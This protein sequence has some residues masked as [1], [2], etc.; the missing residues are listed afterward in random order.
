MPTG[1]ARRCGAGTCRWAC[2]YYC[3]ARCA[4]PGRFL[5]P[6]PPP[7][8]AAMRAADRAATAAAGVPSPEHEA[9]AKDWA[10]HARLASYCSLVMPPQAGQLAQSYSG[11]HAGVWRSG[12]KQKTKRSSDFKTWRPL[13]R[14]QTRGYCNF[15]LVGLHCNVASAALASSSRN[16][17]LFGG[18]VCA[19]MPLS[20]AH[21]A[22]TAPRRCRATRAARYPAPDCRST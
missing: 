18:K 14:T 6:P 12:E 17:L 8:G 3:C 1:T 20:G 22:A 2:F 5:P 13:S 10:A 15:E 4:F 21:R 19:A 11:F 7:G 9:R 16:A